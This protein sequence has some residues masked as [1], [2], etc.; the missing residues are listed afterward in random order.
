MRES[1]NVPNYPCKN[2]PHIKLCYLPRLKNGFL[3]ERSKKAATKA[4]TY[5]AYSARIPAESSRLGDSFFF[6]QQQQV[7]SPRITL[8]QYRRARASKIKNRRARAKLKTTHMLRNSKR[9]SQGRTLRPKPGSD[10]WDIVQG[11]APD[12]VRALVRRLLCRS[13]PFSLIY[14]CPS[15]SLSQGT[16]LRQTLLGKNILG[17]FLGS[18]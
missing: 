15:S 2:V 9:I 1:R 8:R 10:A 4:A 11:L 14:R 6:Q 17:G 16:I 13:L 12:V 18:P 7:T 5:L 3:L